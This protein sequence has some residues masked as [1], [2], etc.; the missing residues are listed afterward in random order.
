MKRLLLVAIL[1]VAITAQEATVK[2]C[3]PYNQFQ[4]H[5]IQKGLTMYETPK[6]GSMLCRMEFAIHG[7]CCSV[8]KIKSYVQKDKNEI[9]NA[10]DTIIREYDSFKH[11]VPHILSLATRFMRLRSQLQTRYNCQRKDRRLQ[12]LRQKNQ[13]KTIVQKPE[14]KP[15]DFGP[16]KPKMSYQSKTSSVIFSKRIPSKIDLKVPSANFKIN[17]K[18]RNVEWQGSKNSCK[19]KRVITKVSVNLTKQHSRCSKTTQRQRRCKSRR[20]KTKKRTCKSRSIKTKLRACKSRRIKRRKCKTQK[21]KKIP[22]KNPIDPAVEVKKLVNQFRIGDHMSVFKEDTKEC[23]NYVA[24]LRASAVC[25]TCSGRRQEFF[26]K[27]K[28]LMDQNTCQSVIQKCYKPLRQLTFLIASLNLIPDL[29]GLNSTISEKTD[30]KIDL[31][32]GGLMQSITSHLKTSEL[33]SVAELFVNANFLV[34]ISR[35]EREIEWKMN[36]SERYDPQRLFKAESNLCSRFIVLNQEPIIVQ[37]KKLFT[38]AKS[39]ANSANDLVADMNKSIHNA[40]VALKSK[41]NMASSWRI[42]SSHLAVTKVASSQSVQGST[43][44]VSTKVEVKT[45]EAYV[46]DSNRNFGADVSVLADNISAYSGVGVTGKN[47]MDF[48][49]LP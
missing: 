5:L 41:T 42:L 36:N 9:N 21:Q 49:M 8:K 48:S 13:I 12:A 29:I 38:D 18:R 40:Q 46:P 32:E 26:L 10:V 7:S 4:D 34:L 33:K 1:V 15:S 47:P 20:I 14:H 45:G 44:V 27:G 28:A 39:S 22:I 17:L 2:S 23:W 43:E 30:T 37:L 11:Y 3:K 24:D 19:P 35:Y 31:E 16:I 25:Y 6:F